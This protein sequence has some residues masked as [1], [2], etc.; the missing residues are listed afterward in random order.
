MLR[1]NKEI[2]HQILNI[3]QMN[4]FFFD[5]QPKVCQNE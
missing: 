5:F 3:S 4:A 1:I 2:F